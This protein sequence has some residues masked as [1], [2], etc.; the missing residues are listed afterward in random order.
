MLYFFHYFFLQKV[1]IIIF[2]YLTQ[3]QQMHIYMN[4]HL[5]NCHIIYK[6]FDNSKVLDNSPNAKIQIEERICDV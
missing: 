1:F 3:E 4:I 2:D 5:T 6:F